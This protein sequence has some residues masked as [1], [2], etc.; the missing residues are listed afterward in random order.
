MLSYSQK[1]AGSNYTVEPQMF[2]A[3]QEGKPYVLNSVKVAESK[4]FEDPAE[5]KVPQALP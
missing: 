1:F 2:G 4:I 3:L 5:N